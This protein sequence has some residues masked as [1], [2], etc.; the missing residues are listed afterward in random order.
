MNPFTITL[1]ALVQDTRYLAAALLF[2]SFFYLS[3]GREVPGPAP[4]GIASSDQQLKPVTPAELELVDRIGQVAA[5]LQKIYEDPAVVSEVHAAIASKF[6]RDERVLLFDLLYPERSALYQLL[7]EKRVEAGSRENGRR[8]HF[9][10]RFRE[11]ASEILGMPRAERI[12]S[13]AR[14]QAEAVLLKN[15][16]GNDFRPADGAISIYHPYSEDFSPD[17]QPLVVAATVDA[18]W[19]DVP[20]P[21][22]NRGHRHGV[23]QCDLIRIDDAYAGEHPIH[24]VGSGA[25]PNRQPPGRVVNTPGERTPLATPDSAVHPLLYLGVVKCTR[26]Y[27]RLISFSGNGGGSELKFI[28]GSAYITLNNNQ[29]VSNTEFDVI[30][31]YFTRKDIRK[32]REQGVYAIWD[33]AWEPECTEQVFGIY[34]EDRQ[35][36]REFSGSIDVKIKY[37]QGETKIT[38]V[39]YSYTVKT[40]DDIIRQINWERASFFRYNR[41]GMGGCGLRNGYTW[42]DCHLPVSYSLP[43]R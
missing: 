24:I 7:Q 31:V 10:R 15:G 26:Q 9:A 13:I 20:D 29:Q 33:P 14:N 22:C 16:N 40:Q 37:P 36:E 34:E 1:C 5:V 28:R 27:D 41:S 2:V 42:Y 17:D 21:A 23:T 12:L 39:G 25:E 4:S 18:D 30:S 8:G 38:P 35:G 19:V 43:Q 6:Y 32:E 3:C 11:A